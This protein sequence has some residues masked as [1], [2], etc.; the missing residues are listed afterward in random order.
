MGWGRAPYGAD[1]YST[2]KIDYLL[3][4]GDNWAKKHEK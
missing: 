1:Q 2:L 4:G 3:A